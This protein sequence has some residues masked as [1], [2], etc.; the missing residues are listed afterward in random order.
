MAISRT[1][2]GLSE[3]LGSIKGINVRK[4]IPNIRAKKNKNCAERKTPKL[5][6][7][8]SQMRRYLSRGKEGGLIHEKKKTVKISKKTEVS[9]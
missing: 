8:E 9:H 5:L 4:M 3:K 1:N 6:E 2:G 7:K